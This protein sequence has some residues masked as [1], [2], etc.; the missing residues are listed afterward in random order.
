MA[1]P[2]YL[3]LSSVFGVATLVACGGS[4][5]SGGSGGSTTS[6]M[7]LVRVSNGFG[8]IL[9]HKAF[10]LDSAGTAT[11]QVTAIR[12]Q[13]DLL[14]NVIS[15]NPLFPAPVFD[16]GTTLP[17]GQPG[18]HFL[19]ATFTR[20]IEVSSVLSSA[21]GQLSSNS[22]TGSVVVSALNPTTGTSSV[23]RGQ[24][25]IDGQTMGSVPVG[26]PPELPLQR[27]VE[28]NDN[29]AITALDIDGATPGL[30]FP[31]TEGTFSGQNQLISPNTLVFVVDSDGDLS[32]HETFPQ[33]VQI[34]MEINSSL[35]S[36]SNRP[37]AE[38]ALAST[39]VGADT[40]RPEVLF[41]PPPNAFPR[42]TPGGG[43]SGVDPLTNIR[44]DFSE[45]MQ[46]WSIGDLLSAKVPSLSTAITVRFGPSTSTVS[47]PFHVEPVSPYDLSSWVLMPSFNFPGEGPSTAECGTFNRVDVDITPNQAT[48]LS[49]NTNQLP[50]TTYF[51]TGEGPSVAKRSSASRVKP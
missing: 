8:E 38:R 11:P 51:N 2:N 40:L 39:T 4:S 17:S 18:N 25:F 1:R 48:D 47:V 49:G 26:S 10:K 45:P 5:S 6:D 33:G 15:S 24:V 13:A 22:L 12:S 46:P 32:T 44:V 19:Y 43:D 31:G 37:L 14:N 20:P 28:I 35:R 30:G 41:N 3:L 16:S 27:W 7:S 50:G 23:I 21:P 9:P 36:T 34:R 42:V 29:G